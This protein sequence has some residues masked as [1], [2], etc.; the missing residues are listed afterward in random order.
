MYLTHKR[1]IEAPARRVSC[2]FLTCHTLSV[3]DRVNVR[4]VD[5]HAKTRSSTHGRSET[6]EMWRMQD[7]SSSDMEVAVSGYSCYKRQ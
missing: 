2:Y 4:V 5:V 6:G 1:L 3:N 7:A